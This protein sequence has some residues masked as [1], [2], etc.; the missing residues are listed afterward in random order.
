[1][2]V[3]NR[4]PFTLYS[5]YF[6]LEW[7]PFVFSPYLRSS[8][9]SINVMNGMITYILYVTVNFN[10]SYNNQQNKAVLGPLL[11]IQSCYKC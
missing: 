7:K 9:F 10:N 5:T 4:Q 1:M 11:E 8:C 2:V 3:N 6:V